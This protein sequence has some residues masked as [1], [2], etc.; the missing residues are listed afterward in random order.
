MKRIERS[1]GKGTIPAGVMLHFKIIER[2][3]FKMRFYPHDANHKLP[4]IG[5]VNIAGSVPRYSGTEVSMF[6]GT[7]A[8]WHE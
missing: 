7:V 3:H 8:W 4:F 2:P 1:T 6:H 5:H